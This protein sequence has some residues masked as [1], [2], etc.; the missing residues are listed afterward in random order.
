MLPMVV[1]VVVALEDNLAPV[2]LTARKEILAVLAA[3]Q[4]VHRL[5]PAAVAVA[6]EQQAAL[7]F[8]QLLAPVALVHLHLSPEL[9]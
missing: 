7:A 2:R 5:P 6:L 4:W 8:L 9:L 3:R 1:R